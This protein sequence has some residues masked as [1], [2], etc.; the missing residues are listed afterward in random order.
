MKRSARYLFVV[1]CLYLITELVLAQDKKDLYYAQ[2]ENTGLYLGFIYLSPDN[3]VLVGIH[4]L[5]L[6]NKQKLLTDT[7]RLAIKGESYMDNVNHASLISKD[8][9][10]VSTLQRALLVQVMNDRFV[11]LKDFHYKDL[12]KQCGNFDLY[13]LFDKGLLARSIKGKLAAHYF[14]TQSADG[15]V[16]IRRSG[17]LTPERPEVVS[18]KGSEIIGFSDYQAL[19]DDI[20]LFSRRHNTLIKYNTVSGEV[21]EINLPL[22]NKQNEAHEFYVDPIAGKCYLIKLLNDKNIVYLM[23]DK[24]YSFTEVFTTPYIVRGIFNGKL[25]VSGM[26]DGA[27]GHFLIPIQG[28]NPEVIFIEND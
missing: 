6:F 24:D 12:R 25:Y 18:Y 1:A 23:S 20:F 7:L 19:G 27:F 16:F 17:Q 22:L 3:F 15:K 8:I 13:V 5:Y 2:P 11:V 14:F 28:Q 21:S 9:L 10:S 26:F 4:D